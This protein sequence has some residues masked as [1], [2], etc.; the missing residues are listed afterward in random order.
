MASHPGIDPIG[1]YDHFCIDPVSADAGVICELNG[2]ELFTVAQCLDFGSEKNGICRELAEQHF[3]QRRAVKSD[4]FE[5]EYLCDFGHILDLDIESPVVL[6]PYALD[7]PTCGRNLAGKAQLVE[8]L[9]RVGSHPDAGSN[10]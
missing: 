4:G 10:L 1:T 8:D 9:H 2:D 7:H 3:L 5:S 6:Q